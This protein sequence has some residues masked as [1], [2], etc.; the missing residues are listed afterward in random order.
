MAVPPVSRPLLMQ[1]TLHPHLP[2]LDASMHSSIRQ[3]CVAELQQLELVSLASC[4]A[5]LSA[6]GHGSPELQPR[7]KKAILE[8]V[9]LAGSSI[10]CTFARC[11]AEL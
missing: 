8:S 6:N 3:P 5:M 11:R 1:P 10:S 7:L 9:I 2:G 4:R